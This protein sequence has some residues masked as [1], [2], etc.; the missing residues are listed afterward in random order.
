MHR[1]LCRANHQSY[2][3]V[4][5]GVKVGLS[6]WGQGTSASISERPD[7]AETVAVAGAVCDNVGVGL[8]VGNDVVDVLIDLALV[9]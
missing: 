6:A 9:L 5:D 4:L 2:L 3:Q 8:E 7:V 1:L